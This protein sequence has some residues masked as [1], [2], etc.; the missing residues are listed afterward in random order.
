M[1]PAT[2]TRHDPPSEV[3]DALWAE[4]VAEVQRLM[5][6]VE[7]PSHPDAEGATM[8]RND[9]PLRAAVPPPTF[10]LTDAD[11]RVGWVDGGTLAFCGFDDEAQAAQAA[12]VARGALVQRMLEESGA[13]AVPLDWQHL[14]LEALADREVVCADG[15]EIATL[16]R[17]GSDPRLDGRFGFA[18]RLPPPHDEVALRATSYAIYRRL[19]A[20]GVA[21]ALVGPVRNESR[22]G[23]GTRDVGRNSAAASDREHRAPLPRIS[24][25]VRL[26]TVATLAA[27]VALL[28]PFFAPEAEIRLPLLTVAAAGFGAAGVSEL[29]RRVGRGDGLGR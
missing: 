5:H 3:V 26:A 16:L 14:T 12:W 27:I 15:H 13:A 11:R 20:A 17:P 9:D 19:R 24:V 18:L 23:S 10:E 22:D 21:W 8:H 29:V 2:M 1:T 25:G 7:A 28:Q 4:L 6:E